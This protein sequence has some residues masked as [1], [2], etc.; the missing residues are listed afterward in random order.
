[1]SATNQNL[2]PLIT[3]IQ[4][5]FQILAKY[6]ARIDRHTRPPWYHST[7]RIP[8][9]TANK[10]YPIEVPR[11]MR[12]WFIQALDSSGLPTPQLN[13]SFAKEPNLTDDP[14]INNYSTILAGTNRS[15][16]TGPALIFLRSDTAN[17]TV[18][19]EIWI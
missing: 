19:M 11:D 16:E 6:L 18:E 13:I 3:E 10:W 12:S 15:E 14:P 4:N 2:Q 7:Q 17:T 8:L 5:G 1:M 9:A